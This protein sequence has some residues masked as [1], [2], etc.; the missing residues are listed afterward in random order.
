[1]AEKRH[2]RMVDFFQGWMEEI[3]EYDGR[4]IPD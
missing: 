4:G 3:G 1:M 2:Q